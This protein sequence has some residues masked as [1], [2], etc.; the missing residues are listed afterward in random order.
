MTRL[1]LQEMRRQ[2]VGLWIGAWWG[3]VL[4]ERLGD[5]T[6]S[7]SWVVTL[8][9]LAAVMARSS[10]LHQPKE[11]LVLPVSQDQL[12]HARWLFATI[13][14]AVLVTTGQAIAMLLPW[15]HGETPVHVETI[16]I[17]G[18]CDLAYLG[19]GY[20]VFLTLPRATAA[21]G[22]LFLGA[23]I[24]VAFFGPLAA[25]GW[26]LLLHPYVPMQWADLAGM[27][28]VVVAAGLGL[29]AWTY[30]YTPAVQ[31][32]MY[33][34]VAE[35]ERHPRGTHLAGWILLRFLGVQP[36]AS[37]APAAPPEESWLPTNRLGSILS[38]VLP[39]F[40][41]TSLLVGGLL[42]ALGDPF[43]KHGRGAFAACWILLAI[44]IS[45]PSWNGRLRQL[46]TLP[47]SAWQVNALQLGTT[48]A[49]W[50]S[51]WAIVSL[52]YL[53]FPARLA[54]SFRPE[55][56]AGLIGVSVLS[57]ASWLQSRSW[58]GLILA[59]LLIGLPIGATVRYAVVTPA[60]AWPASAAF[61]VVAFAAAAWLNQR[62]LT[63]SSSIYK[64]A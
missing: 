24:I 3:Y 30:S 25:F 2:G 57:D 64:H 18:V 63:R 49:L 60:V 53:A 50:L 58:K 27:R 48:T 21:A 29:V 28:G 43:T 37:P 39:Q 54:E 33:R 35:G 15:A 32:R 12:R 6:V 14:P 52:L 1:V 34:P 61:G 8:S 7:R 9:L 5:G 20:V 4:W 13:V 31:T 45:W 46:R 17:S 41:T 22:K 42:V 55:L 19:V 62:A 44:V 10:F 23:G 51:V 59:G 11:L 47:M 26:G 56:I 38:V 16:A 36:K 40:A